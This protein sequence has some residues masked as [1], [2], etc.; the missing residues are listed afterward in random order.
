MRHVKAFVVLSTV[1]VTGAAAPNLATAEEIATESPI[2]V[3]AYSPAYQGPYRTAPWQRPPQAYGP[4]A[5]RY[6]NWRYPNARNAYRAAYP[7][8][9]YRATQAARQRPPAAYIGTAYMGP[10]ARYTARS[11]AE[12]QAIIAGTLRERR[13]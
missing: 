1:I 10:A 11:Y 2:E 5:W 9:S 12:R 3:A 6:S 8:N 13:W 4:N 7:A